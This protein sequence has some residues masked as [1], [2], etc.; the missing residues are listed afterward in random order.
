MTD[1]PIVKKFLP[2]LD[3][4]WCFP[5][6]EGVRMEMIAERIHHARG[7]KVVVF[8]ERP[9]MGIISYMHDA[10]WIPGKA[11]VRITGSDTGA[12]VHEACV[13]R[14]GVFISISAADIIGCMR[15]SKWIPAKVRLVTGSD[16]GISVVWDD[17]RIDFVQ[18]RSYHTYRQ[19]RVPIGPVVVDL[20]T[21]DEKVF[22]ETVVPLLTL[23]DP[24]VDFIVPV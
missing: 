2:T 14:V 3:E 5:A 22:I 1:W 6:R 11:R 20:A 23:K 9:A 4:S 24:R 13:R 21:I 7:K 10:K 19:L 15:D 16:S 17:H 18:T 8:T 12:S